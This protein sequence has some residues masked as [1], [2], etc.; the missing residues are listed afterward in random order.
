MDQNKS[1][2]NNRS[3]KTNLYLW[4]CKYIL[5]VLYRQYDSDLMLWEEEPIFLGATL[6]IIHSFILGIH[7]FIQYLDYFLFTFT[8]TVISSDPPHAQMTMSDL[9][10]YHWI[11]Y[12]FILFIFNFHLWLL[13]NGE[14][15]W[16]FATNSDFLITIS[17]EQN[18]ANLRYFK[19]WIL[20]DQI[21]W[22][23]NIKGLL[24]SKINLLFKN[25][26]KVTTLY[27]G[28]E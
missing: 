10:R 9:Q 19:L 8:G 18:V 26:N 23:W 17:L 25:K 11:R 2:N 16:V 1:M 12:A 21:I 20:L 7:F 15:N 4:D 3:S 13:C 22:V 27:S 24:N 14:R 6:H 5:Y 28:S